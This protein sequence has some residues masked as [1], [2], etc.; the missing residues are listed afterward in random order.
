MEL[1]TRFWKKVQ[2]Q[3][4]EECWPWL[5]GCGGRYRRGTI[6]YL[7]KMIYASRISWLLA[8]GQLPDTDKQVLHTCDNPNCVNPKHLW[9]GTQKDNMQDASTK[10]RMA[11]Q[12]ITHCPQGH[13]YTEAN[14]YKGKSYPGR[15]CVICK[16]ARSEETRNRTIS[17]LALL[18]ESGY[19]GELYYQG[20]TNVHIR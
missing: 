17:N 7:G 14:T 4:N 20:T 19:Y 8:F 13:E 2:K 11:R 15:T 3:S 16:R 1:S 6:K 5:G 12:K 10:G 18:L 9:L